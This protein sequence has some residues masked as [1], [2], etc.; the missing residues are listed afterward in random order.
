M[1]VL[2]GAQ[3][4]WSLWLPLALSDD[5]Q[6]HQHADWA[7]RNP[8]LT[9][10]D[11]APRIQLHYNNF[12]ITQANHGNPNMDSPDVIPSPAR[13]VTIVSDQWGTNV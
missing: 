13:Q 12:E 7:L 5:E 9:T 4:P 10:M 2:Q 3:E 11:K 1:E 6:N 8:P